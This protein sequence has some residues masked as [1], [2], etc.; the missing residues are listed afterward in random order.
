MFIKKNIRKLSNKNYICI[1]VYY[2]FV[3]LLQNFPVR[4]TL[5][6]HYLDK[7]NIVFRFMDGDFKE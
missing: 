3:K 1:I 4:K 2:Q 5:L 7:K 6:K